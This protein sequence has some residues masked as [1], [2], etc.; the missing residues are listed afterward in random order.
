LVN[1]ENFHAAIPILSVSPEQAMEKNLASSDIRLAPMIAERDSI[2][3]SIASSSSPNAGLGAVLGISDFRPSN[4]TAYRV[5]LSNDGTLN[6]R[7]VVADRDLD[8][9]QRYANITFFRDRQTVARAT[10]N[11]ADGSF[12]LPNLAVGV[13]GVIASGPAGYSAFEFEVLPPSTE[14]VGAKQGRNLPVSFQPPAAAS[15]LYVFLIPPKLMVR[16]RDE[17]TN[18]YGSTPAPSN[19]VGGPSGAFPGGGGFGGGGSGGAGI[20]GGGGLGA[21]GALAVAGIVAA[22][23]TSESDSST[24]TNQP[25]VV[26]SPIAP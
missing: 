5:H 12:G 22:M 6:G 20:G 21:G 11:A 24:S 3:A 2:L 4:V 25:P 9:S 16:V 7:V 10:A 8:R 18:A 26:V 13:Y 23:A 14:L 17:I 15:K 19:M 1:D